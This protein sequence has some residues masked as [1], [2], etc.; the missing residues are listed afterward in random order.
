MIALALM[1]HLAHNA[2]HLLT[3]AG[4]LVPVL[5]DPYGTGR[6][7]LGT[8]GMSFGPLAPQSVIWAL[9]LTLV[10][11]GLAWALR[12][13]ERIHRR[14]SAKSELGQWK[15]RL[16]AALFPLAITLLDLWLLAQPMEMRSGL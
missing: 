14:M 11:L 1:Y 6:D 9:Q 3:E 8:A 4:S 12:I 5:S 10:L 15:L 7:F 13:G 16:V 2:G